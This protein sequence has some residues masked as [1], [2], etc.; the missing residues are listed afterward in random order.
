MTETHTTRAADEEAENKEQLLSC[1]HDDM[2]H[3]RAI[4]VWFGSPEDVG[5][6]VLLPPLRSPC[7]VGGFVGQ[8]KNTK[9]TKQISMKLGGR[10]ERRLKEDSL[11]SGADRGIYF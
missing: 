10:T 5:G 6:G 11:N 8:Q 1:N 3:C 2:I 4:R 9:S 7:C